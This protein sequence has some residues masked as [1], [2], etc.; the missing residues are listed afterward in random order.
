MKTEANKAKRNPGRLKRLVSCQ[1][2]L[3]EAEIDHVIR[4]ME[5]NEG[6]LW[7]EK[8]DKWT[9]PQNIIKKLLRAQ[10]NAAN[11]KSCGGEE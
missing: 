1:V 5:T 6:G 10:V 9:Y 11:A 8:T 7:H 4:L 3:T 2:A